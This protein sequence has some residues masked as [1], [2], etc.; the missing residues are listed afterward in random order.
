MYS[1]LCLIV[2]VSSYLAQYPILRI[3]HGALQFTSL[4]DL[5]NQTPSQL[6]WEA[7]SCDGCS[8]TYPPLSIAMY[9]FIHGLD[10]TGI[11]YPIATHDVQAYLY[12][13]AGC[14]YVNRL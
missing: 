6:L 3:A 9:S 12:K 7:S 14:V 1:V 4:T 13:C 8:Y 10:I 2:K 11:L 5:S